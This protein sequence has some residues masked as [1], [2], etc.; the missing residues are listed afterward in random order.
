MAL[1]LPSFTPFLFPSVKVSFE[2]FRTLPPSYMAD[3]DC[4]GDEESEEE[5]EEGKILQSTLFYGSFDSFISVRP[6]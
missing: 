3:E 6:V 5:E 2:K 4:N 1:L